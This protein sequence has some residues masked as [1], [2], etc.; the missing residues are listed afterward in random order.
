M[1]PRFIDDFEKSSFIERC[2]W[3]N[4]LKLYNPFPGYEIMLMP[5]EGYSIYDVM[6]YKIENHIITNRVFIEIKVRKV[7]YDSYFFETKKY[8]SIVKLC[9]E[10]LCLRDDEFKILYLNFTPTGTYI[11]NT[12]I[13]KDMNVTKQVMNKATMSDRTNKV[14]K[15]KWDMPID[16]SKKYNYIW[17]ERQLNDYYDSY[18]VEKVKEKVKKVKGLEE[19]LFIK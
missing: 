1:K 6:L 2:A 5:Y 18:L 15:T 17:D 11:W 4:F 16:K 13:I 14:N 9:K 7:V 8:N 12:D 3:K 10:E 19:I